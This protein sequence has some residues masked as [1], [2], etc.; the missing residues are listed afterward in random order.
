MELLSTFWL[1]NTS[2]LFMGTFLNEFLY[3][4]EADPWLVTAIVTTYVGQNA[5]LSLVWQFTFCDELIARPEESYRL[6]CVVV[7]DLETSRMRR[8]WP[9]LGCSATEIKWQ[10]TCQVQCWYSQ[11][12]QSVL[13]VIDGRMIYDW[14]A[15]ENK[16]QTLKVYNNPSAVGAWFKPST[17]LEFNSFAILLAGLQVFLSKIGNF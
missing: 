1:W 12:L 17:C 9:A 3:M 16:S 7:C 15:G 6:W 13:R 4:P 14:S 8:P 11:R 2:R 5:H 10:F